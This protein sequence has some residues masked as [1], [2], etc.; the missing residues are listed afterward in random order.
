MS[1]KQREEFEK[2]AKSHY[3][4]MRLG[5]VQGFYSNEAVQESWFVWQQAWISSRSDL[6]VVLPDSRDN[7]LDR[8]IVQH[9]LSQAGI[10]Y[11]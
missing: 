10:S 1:D 4:F 2:W 8:Q 5:T 9:A 11:E 6:V 7:F 3:G